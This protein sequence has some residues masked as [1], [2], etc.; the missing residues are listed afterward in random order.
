MVFRAQLRVWGRKVKK[1]RTLGPTQTDWRRSGPASSARGPLVLNSRCPR[2]PEKGLKCVL[3]GAEA[4]RPI[5]D[6]GPSCWCQTH[7]GWAQRGA[8]LTGAAGQVGPGEFVVRGEL[9]LGST[10][11]RW[12]RPEIVLPRHG[13]CLQAGMTASRVQPWGLRDKGTQR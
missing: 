3:P 10:H 2:G 4:R 6:S 11:W 9:G 13:N 7:G 8:G 1:G 5:L 12:P